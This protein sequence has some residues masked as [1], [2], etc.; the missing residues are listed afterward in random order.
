MI[1]FNQVFYIKVDENS[2]PRGNA[3]KVD[4]K[5]IWVQVSSTGDSIEIDLDKKKPQ[6]FDSKEQEIEW[7]RQSAKNALKFKDLVE[8]GQFIPDEIFKKLEAKVKRTPEE[9]EIL[10]QALEISNFNEK[11]LSL[12]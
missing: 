3:K 9:E 4:N 7:D 6:S 1:N 2:T 11:V 8:S 10:R 12:L 5:K